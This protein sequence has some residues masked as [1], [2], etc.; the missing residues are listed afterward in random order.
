[1][2]CLLRHTCAFLCVFMP[3]QEVVAAFVDHLDLPV[4]N[5]RLHFKRTLFEL[6]RRCCEVGAHY[7]YRYRKWACLG[8]L[9]TALQMPL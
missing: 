6:A 5:G 3:L 9:S 4:I 7:L 8:T 1:M 2:R